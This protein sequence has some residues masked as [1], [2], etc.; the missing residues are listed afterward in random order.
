MT[1]KGDAERAS[2]ARTRQRAKIMEIARDLAR[3]G[4]HADHTTIFRELEAIEGF[5]AERTRI[6]KLCARAR[7]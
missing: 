2:A 1:A 5:S 3:S 4:W 6:D 7:T